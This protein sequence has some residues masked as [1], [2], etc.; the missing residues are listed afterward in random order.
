MAMSRWGQEHSFH[1]MAASGQTELL[2]HF[3]EELL[4]VDTKADERHKIADHDSVGPQSLLGRA[5]SRAKPNLAVVKVLVEEA[6]LDVNGYS[7]VRAP[8]SKLNGTTPLHI[9]ATGQ[10]FWQI[11]ALEYLLAHGADMD[12]TNSCGF[13]PLLMAVSTKYPCGFWREKTAAIL[14]RHGADPNASDPNSGTPVLAMSNHV[15]V[16]RALLEHGADI[17]RAPGALASAV[18]GLDFVLAQ[19]LLEAGAGVNDMVVGADLWVCDRHHTAN[20]LAPMKPT[21]PKYLIHVAAGQIYSEDHCNSRGVWELQ[22]SRTINALLSRGAD[23]TRYYK[24]KST[25]LQR[26]IEEDIPLQPF[27]EALHGVDIERVG[28]GGR[29]LL[30]SACIPRVVRHGNCYSNERT[31]AVIHLE[32]AVWLLDRGARWDVSDDRGRKPIH[33][34]CTVTDPFDETHNAIFERLLTLGDSSE[35][36]SMDN[37]GR[38]PLF[39]SLQ[40]QQYW[41]ATRLIEQGAAL[42]SA[43][44]NGDTVLHVLVGGLFGSKALAESARS[45]FD[46]LLRLSADINARNKQGQ[47]PLFILL[48]RWWPTKENAT[49]GFSYCD[50]LPIFLEAGADLRAVTD[51]GSSLLHAVAG[52]ERGKTY[53]G[54]YAQDEELG[55][56]FER[57]LEL[58][59]NPRQEDDKLRSALDMAVARGWSTIVDLFS[60]EGK[61]RLELRKKTSS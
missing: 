43:D 4:T 10:Y 13:S 61:R 12:A 57:L 14:L 40:A 41:A 11:E 8:A 55:S 51:Q 22:K 20:H 28:L 53:P 59:L 15:G 24:D 58:G 3:V 31:P 25:V 6:G 50:A 1:Y 47:T 2:R 29:T 23:V 35:L 33:W 5:C 34:M 45:L 46:S 39:L 30:I 7:H 37:D 26:I 27:F 38:T 19:V 44:T 36:E 21:D 49:K 60:D 48:S 18:L 16:T 9:L 32:A 42:P 56:V 17:S 52:Q 54:G